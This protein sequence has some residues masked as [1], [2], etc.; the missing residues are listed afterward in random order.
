MSSKLNKL[1]KAGL[2]IPEELSA[3]EKRVLESLTD[4]EVKSLLSAKRKLGKGM[5]KIKQGVKK[6]FCF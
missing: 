1:K 5:V 4:A 2:A 3:R 6:P